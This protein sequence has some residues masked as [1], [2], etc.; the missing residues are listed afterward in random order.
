MWQGR[1]HTCVR[2]SGIKFCKAACCLHHTQQH[3]S[4]YALSPR[5]ASSKPTAHIQSLGV[6]GE[7]R[8]VDDDSKNV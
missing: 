8:E 2:E 6:Q 5:N 1:V 4:S 3:K 7:E